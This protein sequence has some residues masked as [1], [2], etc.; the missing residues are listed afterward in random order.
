VPEQ[1]P[2][3]GEPGFPVFPEGEAGGDSRARERVI[4]VATVAALLV[5]V[6][7]LGW[8]A[9]VTVDP[10]V[11][12]LSVPLYLLELHAAVGLGLYAF[13]LWDV[14]SGP[15]A[16]PVTETRLRVAV[17]I[18]TW[19]EP[20]EVLAPTIAAA[21]ALR[22]AH[23]TWV[24]D[25]GDRPH[26]AELAADLGARYLR[27]D[28]RSHAKAGNLNHALK[29]V[30][31]DVVAVLDAD[32]VARP[33]FLRDTLGYFDDQRVALVQTPQD[34]YNLESFEHSRGA[35]LLADP[36]PRRPDEPGP[37]RPRAGRLPALRGAGAPGPGRRRPDRH[38]RVRTG[39]VAG[40]R[41]PHPPAVQR[42]RRPRGGAAAGGRLSVR[43]H[44]GA[45][46]QPGGRLL[47]SLLQFRRF[48]DRNVQV[49][50]TVGT[51]GPGDRLP[52]RRSSE[53]EQAAH[54]RCVG[55]SS[56]PAATR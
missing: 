7:Y 24:L 53:V 46:G 19:N 54:N 5:T 9:V 13:S 44:A 16:R 51:G 45:C 11:W 22:P 49:S 41:H 20:P 1:H 30:D 29:V 23:E 14:G 56:P 25:D 8:R 55:G 17:L 31:A 39:A 6:A 18:P 15:R 52:W 32:H 34:F 43:R 28:D 38:R 47:A 48:A 50:T 33:G 35:D 2:A 27:R 40:D 4:R 3:A 10:A 21:V 37:G 42:R 36:A 26:I 12:W